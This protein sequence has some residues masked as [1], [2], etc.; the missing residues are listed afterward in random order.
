MAFNNNSYLRRN[1]EFMDI[2]DLISVVAQF[3]NMEADQ[4]YKDYIQEFSAKIQKEVDALHHENDVIM[5]KLDEIL[6]RMN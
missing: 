4:K 1:I 2:L 5:S 6:E 3:S